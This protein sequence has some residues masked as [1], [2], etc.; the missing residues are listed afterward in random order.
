MHRARSCAAPAA[1]TSPAA[2]V[3]ARTARPR[4]RAASPIAGP[5]PRRPSPPDWSLATPVS[6]SAL[7][8]GLQS[9]AVSQT[10]T[11]ELLWPAAD[12]VPRR[13][14]QSYHVLPSKPPAAALLDRAQSP[15]L[16]QTAAYCHG[17][18]H[19]RHRPNRPTNK[20]EHTADRSA[21]RKS[22]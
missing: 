10:T 8:L 19:S 3:S 14:R 13:A 2:S 9:P 6:A 18:S 4:L 5:P 1:S 22:P 21:A 20:H 17:N 15:G 12:Q 7:E 11:A 16:L